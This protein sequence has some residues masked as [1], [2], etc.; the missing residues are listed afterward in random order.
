MT[1]DVLISI[2]L[3]LIITGITGVIYNYNASYYQ[4]NG[5]DL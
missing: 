5:E 4:Y 3:F 2:G 1:P